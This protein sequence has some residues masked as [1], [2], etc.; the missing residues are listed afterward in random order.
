MH[1]S[2][3]LWRNSLSLILQKLR[4]NTY[5]DSL[6]LCVFVCFVFKIKN[7]ITILHNVLTT[8]CAKTQRQKMNWQLEF[9]NDS[10]ENT[11][12]QRKAIWFGAVNVGISSQC[13]SLSPCKFL[14]LCYIFCGIEY[15]FIKLTLLILNL[16]YIT[17]KK[18]HT[19]KNIQIQN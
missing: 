16:Q 1:L 13:K 12:L 15:M 3:P 6:W 14:M 8:P 5:V 17:Q 4:V 2:I 11:V 18:L 19:T 7:K 9:T 10:K